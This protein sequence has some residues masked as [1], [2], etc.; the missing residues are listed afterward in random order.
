MDYQW[1]TNCRYRDGH[2]T[3]R[4]SQLSR[5][6]SLIPFHFLDINLPLCWRR[7]RENLT[8]QNTSAESQGPCSMPYERSLWPS[9]QRV[10]K[11]YDGSSGVS[12][13][14]YEGPPPP[15]P[16]KPRDSFQKSGKSSA[17]TEITNHCVSTRTKKPLRELVRIMDLTNVPVLL[18]GSCF[19]F[20]VSS[21]GR[22]G[23]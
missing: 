20:S 13:I 11:H 10:P 12:F 15:T 6:T 4:G 1:G 9:T 3:L 5:L 8:S 16:T 23:E 21:K 17:R 14:R 19:F 7:S 22:N 2:M 18:T